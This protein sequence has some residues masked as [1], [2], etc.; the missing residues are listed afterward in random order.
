M[1]LKYDYWAWYFLRQWA[2]EKSPFC[3]YCNRTLNK[4]NI[5]LDHYIPKSKGG[6]D[7]FSN[8]VSCCG[9][10]NNKKG[11]KMPEIFMSEKNELHGRDGEN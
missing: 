8:L 3:Y 10:C 11:D 6:S 1:E 9:D 5:T 2:L 7:D 4:Y